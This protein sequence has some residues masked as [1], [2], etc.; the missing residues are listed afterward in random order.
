MFLNFDKL[1]DRHFSFV[2]LRH[3]FSFKLKI[4]RKN[5]RTLS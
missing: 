3:N 4:S 1:S 2:Q 5:D